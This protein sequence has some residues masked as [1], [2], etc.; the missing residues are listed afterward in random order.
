MKHVIVRQAL[1]KD[2][3]E[4][5]A[6]FHSLWPKTGLAEHARELDLLLAGDFPGTLPALFSWPRSLAVA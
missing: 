5:A 1:S 6:M 2:T 4:L 3:S